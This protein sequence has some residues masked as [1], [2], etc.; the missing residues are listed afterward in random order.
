MR[1][2]F[3]QNVPKNKCVCFIEIIWL[4]I[5]W[6]L[7]FGN[8]ICCSTRLWV[9]YKFTSGLFLVNVFNI[10]SFSSIKKIIRLISKG[11]SNMYLKVPFVKNWHSQNCNFLSLKKFI[12]SSVFVEFQLTQRSLNF[13]NCCGNLK[14]WDLGAKVCVVFLL[15]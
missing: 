6:R 1:L 10:C 2:N 15:L 9:C 5:H 7:I 4:R 8:V 14:I 11:L 12:S 13:K 3:W